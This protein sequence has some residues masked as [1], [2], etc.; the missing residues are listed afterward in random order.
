MTLVLADAVAAV[1]ERL[2]EYNQGQWQ[3]VELV[4][5]IN[6]GCRDV[7]RRSECLFDEATIVITGGIQEYTL[8]SNMLRV[9]AVDYNRSGDGQRYP[10]EYIDFNA[11][12][13]IW[14]LSQTVNQ[15]TPSYFTSWGTPP[16][17]KLILYPTPASSGS[18]RVKFYRVSLDAATSDDLL[19]MPE[20]WV[21]I[22]LDYVEFRALRKDR[23]PFWTDAKQM[24][25]AN[26]DNLITLSRRF[27]DASG[28]VTPSN[29]GYIPW[30]HG[31]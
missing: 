9:Y 13:E 24:Y 4:R 19:D 8:P 11:A 25:E 18:C 15:G 7:T 1:R 14:G 26:L 10:L 31:G 2:N 27:V 16:A 6:E 28:Q 5:W 22:V 21:D 17:A 29:P 30:L 12:P 3:D 23:D 20:G